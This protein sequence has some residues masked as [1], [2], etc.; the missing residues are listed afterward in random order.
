MPSCRWV[1]VRSMDND[2]GSI[3]LRH[4]TAL[5]TPYMLVSQFGH[6]SC[7]P[8]YTLP[9]TKKLQRHR[10][11]SLEMKLYRVVHHE[12]RLIL[13][14]CCQSLATYSRDSQPCQAGTV[15]IKLTVL[16]LSSPTCLNPLSQVPTKTASGSHL[17]ANLGCT[18]N[19]EQR[20]CQTGR[21]T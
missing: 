17:K 21:I 15:R 2:R 6:E 12:T 1:I 7:G 10:G 19:R 8:A 16:R 13:T 3:C 18:R 14:H 9:N 20:T 4:N 11:R 5:R